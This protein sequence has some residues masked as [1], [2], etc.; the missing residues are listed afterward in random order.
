MQTIRTRFMNIICGVSLT[1]TLLLG[2]LS[3]YLVDR[4]ETASAVYSLNGQVMRSAADINPIFLHSED[5]VQFVAN[6]MEHSV[7]DP[8]ALKSRAVRDEVE[9]RLNRAFFNAVANIRGVNGYYVHFNE[10]LAGEADGFWYARP[11]AKSNFVSQ[12]IT[13]VEKYG[14]DDTARTSWYYEPLKA[15]GAVWME[16]YT[17]ANNGGRM[18]SYAIPVYVKGQ[19]VG[20]V[21]I[22]LDFDYLCQTVD[23]IKVYESGGGILFR[24]L[25]TFYSPL[26]GM[27]KMDAKLHLVPAFGTSKDDA[28]LNKTDTNGAV[29]HY[30]CEGTAMEMAFTTLRNGMKLGVTAPSSEIYAGRKII[31]CVVIILLFI[32][33]LA[34][35]LIA[36]H[37]A[38]R[39]V[40]PLK[41]IGEA[42][43]RMGR[44][45]YDKPLAYVQRDEIGLLAG[46]MNDTMTRMRDY[47]GAMK[48]QAYRDE[49][50]Q[51]KNVAAYDYK[52]S[53]LDKAIL[54]AAPLAF[55]VVMVDL[56]QLKLINDCFGHE[57]GNIAIKTLCQA[58]CRI[59]KH[60]PVYRVGGDEFVVLLEGEDYQ[61]REALFAKVRAFENS[62]DMTADCPWAQLSAS[63]G[64][65]VYEP[66]RDKTYQDVFNRADAKMYACKQQL[67]ACR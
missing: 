53:Q 27:E 42:A 36:M 59:Y 47:V 63:I 51:V 67:G 58:V 39:I 61:N 7:K 11:D 57:K 30:Y 45:E 41:E 16:P 60:S 40:R 26:K 15:K 65:A 43:K 6:T 10:D 49:L 31:I 33:A 18:I 64:M 2:G 21:G 55:G 13:D 12:P 14:R 22:D 54:S 46:H 19:F 24:D 34:S 8:A 3:V 29:L 32:V 5:S 25:D 4:G 50:T 1:L 20:V 17:N 48:R 62:R 35:I 37:A 28:L 52:I 23:G 38:D 9:A 66:H 44:G 56:N